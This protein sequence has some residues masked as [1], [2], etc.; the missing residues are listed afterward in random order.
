MNVD[1]DVVAELLNDI[2]NTTTGVFPED[3][4][5]TGAADALLRLQDVYNLS[6]SDI[7]RGR[8]IGSQVAPPLSREYKRMVH[9]CPI[10][11]G[12]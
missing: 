5:M 7:A 8:L 1:V 9:L 4:D 11:A 6:T 10:S 3:I 12:K 2:V